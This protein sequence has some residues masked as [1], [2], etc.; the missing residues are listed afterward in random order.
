M[1]TFQMVCPR[2]DASHGDPF[3]VV[4]RGKVDWMLCDVC[5]EQFH[6]LVIECGVCEEE[7]VFTWPS[8]PTTSESEV[9]CATCASRLEFPYEA[10]FATSMSDR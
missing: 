2:C 1:T 8:V 7:N 9:R 10:G 4:S 3:E 5:G 6:H